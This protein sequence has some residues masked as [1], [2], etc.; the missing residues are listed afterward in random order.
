MTKLFYRDTFFFLVLQTTNW[1]RVSVS[2]FV[3][4]GLYICLARIIYLSVFIRVVGVIMKAQLGNYFVVTS[5]Y[6][7]NGGLV[8]QRK[9]AML[10]LEVGDNLYRPASADEVR[11]FVADHPVLRD[12]FFYF[13][14]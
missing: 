12:N 13:S 5:G 10:F 4:S 6:C 3:F 7:E 11:N 9:K 1:N 8:N 14:T 2:G